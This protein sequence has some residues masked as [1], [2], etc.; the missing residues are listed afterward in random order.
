MVRAAGS[1]WHPDIQFAGVTAT[2]AVEDSQSAEAAG[3]LMRL[4]SQFVE[5]A[6]ILVAD[7][8]SQ[9]AG[10]QFLRWADIPA[11]TAE[12]YNPSALGTDTLAA[13]IAP[14]RQMSVR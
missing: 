14:W 11:E 6:E 8:G 9:L 5:V 10:E 3:I 1:C 12:D 7:P 4:E 2:A 13:P